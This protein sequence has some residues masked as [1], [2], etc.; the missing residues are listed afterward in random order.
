MKKKFKQIFLDDGTVVRAPEDMKKYLNYNIL[1]LLN[2]THRSGPL[3]MPVLY[4]NIKAYPDYLAL[5]SQKSLYKMSKRTA[6]CFYQFDNEFDG[7]TGLFWAI[8]NNDTRRLEEF[9]LRFKTIKYFIG[10]DYSTFGDIHAIENYYR[11]FRARVVCLWF[12]F[13]LG[14]VVIPN[15][16]YAKTEQ[17]PMFLC[18]LEECNVI[19]INA[20]GHV[21]Y[22]RERRL[23]K[24]VIKYVCDNLP[25]KAIIVYSACGN[26]S[27]C[28]D[29]FNYAQEKN[30]QIIIPGNTLRD[31][32]MERMDKTCHQVNQVV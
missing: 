22:A 14:A 29:L 11:V 23:L 25:L 9:K 28:L 2:K 7:K 5:Y 16:S 10:P 13:E 24:D 12:T 3:D 6:V 30:I 18:G 1:N 20:K 4:C 32:N 26:D 31:R 21:R 27:T 17:L 19:A 8:Y 15:I